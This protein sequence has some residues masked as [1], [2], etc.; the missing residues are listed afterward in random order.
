[1]D[2]MSS[3]R[4]EGQMIHRSGLFQQN[5]T[6]A[7]RLLVGTQTWQFR[8]PS[9]E[10]RLSCKDPQIANVQLSGTLATMCIVKSSTET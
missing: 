8:Y 2:Q 4:K 6:Q 9:E 3:S 1:M 10:T 7:S 5:M